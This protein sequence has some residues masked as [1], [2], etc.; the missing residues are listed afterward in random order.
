MGMVS[1]SDTYLFFGVLEK[2]KGE[3]ELEQVRE[4]L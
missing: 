2:G 4:R 3:E 1:V